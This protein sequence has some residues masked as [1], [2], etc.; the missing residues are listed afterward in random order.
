M[1]LA[2]PKRGATNVPSGKARRGL[3][4]WMTPLGFLSM[5]TRATSPVAT[6]QGWTARQI[7]LAADGLAVG[8]GCHGGRLQLKEARYPTRL[9]RPRLRRPRIGKRNQPCGTYVCMAFGKFNG[10]SGR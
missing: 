8:C 7:V 1:R 9:A 2:L 5:A 3:T 4:R 10:T 6:N